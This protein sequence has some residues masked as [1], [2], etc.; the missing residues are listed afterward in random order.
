MSESEQATIDLGKRASDTIHLHILGGNV[1]RWVALRLNDGGSDGIPYDTRRDAIRH[2]LHEQYCCYV[3]I[4]PDG[5][6][7][8]DAMRFIL[9]NRAIYAAGYRLTDPDDDRE[10]I[11]P[12][13]NEETLALLN[14][15]SREIL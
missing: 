7:P 14:R 4:P 15:Y 11:P 13:T 9:V 3:K 2:Q 8:N 5:M 6:A 10:V 12:M 1:G